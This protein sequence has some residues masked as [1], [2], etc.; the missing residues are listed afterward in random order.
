MLV[1]EELWLMNQCPLRKLIGCYILYIV[2]RARS[3]HK[4][5]LLVCLLINPQHTRTGSK[6]R[7]ARICWQVDGTV[8]K[9]IRQLDFRCVFVFTLF[10]SQFWVCRPIPGCSVIGRVECL[11]QLLSLWLHSVHCPAAAGHRRSWV[12]FRGGPTIPSCQNSSPSC[13]NFFSVRGGA[14]FVDSVLPC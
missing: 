7:Y 9:C 2:L 4:A 13:Q 12:I 6:F 5:F 3:I 11:I 8:D 14:K 10:S 1:H